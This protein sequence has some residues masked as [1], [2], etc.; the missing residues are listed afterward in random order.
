[1]ARYEEKR[2]TNPTA[3]YLDWDQHEQ[4][5]SYWDANL[6]TPARVPVNLPFK[7]VVI[8]QR[9]VIMGFTND[10]NK[11]RIYSNEI[12]DSRIG[13]DVFNVRTKD[14]VIAKG[15]YKDIKNVVNQNGGRLC[16][17]IHAVC[18]NEIVCIRVKGNGLTSW[19]NTVGTK[20]NSER[21]PD[22]F[23]IVKGF[24]EGE[25][26]GEFY[27]Y[28]VF[29]FAGSLNVT[30]NKKVDDL[31]KKLDKYYF[32]LSEEQSRRAS[33]IASQIV[34]AE[35]PQAVQKPA[36]Q[37]PRNLMPAAAPADLFLADGNDDDLPF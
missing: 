17:V 5:F 29:D 2:A 23:I 37:Q 31:D 9:V 19:I 30:Q 12:Q 14:G 34:H 36:P 24:E 1:M 8:R 15:V 28:P 6:E 21:L 18:E 22:E 27:T 35:I 33:Q 4:S 25:Y 20:K 32:D 13:F 3:K 16:K 11:D 26:N 10:E 7:F